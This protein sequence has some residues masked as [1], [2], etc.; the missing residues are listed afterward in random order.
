MANQTGKPTYIR[1]EDVSVIR[2]I[3][4]EQTRTIAG[5]ITVLIDEYC[6]A[7]GLDRATGLPRKARSAVSS[8]NGK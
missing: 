3:A 2:A 4:E 7:H 6:A 1:Q 5:Q 8:R